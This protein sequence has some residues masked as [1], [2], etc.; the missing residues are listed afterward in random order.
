LEIIISRG[1]E[2]CICVTDSD[3]YSPSSSVSATARDCSNAAS[4]SRWPVAHVATISRELENILPRK[5]VNEIIGP[6][7]QTEWQS[8]ESLAEKSSPLFPYIDIKK[9][10]YMHW[11]F[12]LPKASSCRTFWDNE[13]NNGTVKSA[14]NLDCLDNQACDLR[15]PDKCN[16]VISQG[17]GTKVAE[18]VLDYLKN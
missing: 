1:E 2:T 7:Q 11:V 16:C 6:Q 10:T 12:K 3:K 13:L 17:M 9:G 8:I 18:K 15:D 14:L 5:F 4:K